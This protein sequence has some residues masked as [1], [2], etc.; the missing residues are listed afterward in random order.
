[1]RAVTKL[2]I[3]TLVTTLF[4]AFGL[5]S[6]GA[7][8]FKKIPVPKWIEIR[9][10]IALPNRVMSVTYANGRTYM[11][12]IKETNPRS[13]CNEVQL[14]VGDE[15]KIIPHSASNSYEYVLEPKPFMVSDWY[16]YEE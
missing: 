2:I 16:A 10:S 8:E 1:M 4:M 13:D 12:R 3:A 15:I 6:V 14:G 9:E 7:S 5:Q 11:F